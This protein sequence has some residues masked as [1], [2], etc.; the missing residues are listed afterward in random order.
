MGFIS[1]ELTRKVAQRLD[2]LI[3]L[4]GIAEVVDG[5]I[6]KIALDL[7]D[8]TLGD[9]VPIEYRDDILALLEAFAND[10]Y[11]GVADTAADTIN[12]LIDIPGSEEGLEKI[13]L[14]ANLQMIGNFILYLK[15]KRASK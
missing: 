2:N 6:I 3:K 5:P 4:K 7:F 1:K 15:N 9:N 8:E 13:W 12:K 11:A 14:T 10:D